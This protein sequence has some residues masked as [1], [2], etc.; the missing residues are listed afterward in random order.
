MD[1]V[2]S[3]FGTNEPLPVEHFFLTFWP[4]CCA[5][6]ANRPKSEEKSVQLAEVHL[7]RTYFLQNPYFKGIASSMCFDLCTAKSGTPKRNQLLIK[8]RLLYNQSRYILFLTMFEFSRPVIQKASFLEVK[9]FT[10]RHILKWVS[11]K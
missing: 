10:R 8:Y 4:V 2:R 9:L 1:F 5:H 11:K 6:T 7:Y 3:S